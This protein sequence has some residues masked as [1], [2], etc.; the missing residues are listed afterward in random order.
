MNRLRRAAGA[1][2]LGIVLMSPAVRADPLSLLFVVEQQRA[3][4]VAKLARQW[5]DAF[6]GLPPERSLTHEQLSGRLW[7]LRADRLFAV[8]IAAD[9]ETVESVL[10][11]ARGPALRD[12]AGTKALGD[13]AADLTYT[14]VNPCRILDTRSTPAGPLAPGV[15]RTFDGYSAS[16]S[17]QGGTGSTC[18]IPN[19]V[20]ALAL[21]VYAVNPTNLGFIKVWPAN[22]V[23]P[24]V[25][26]VN[27][28]VG[29][30]AIA[31]G[32]LVPVEAANNNRFTAKSPATVDFIADVVGYFKPPGD[33]TGLDI[34]VAG[35]RVMRYE[36]NP[37]SPNLIGGS[38]ANY[39]TAGV[40]GATIGGGGV[41]TGD[42]DPDYV[43]EA[44]NS[45]T[46]VY[47]TVGGGY[48]N[49]A[50]DNLGTINDAGF[51]TVGGGY[52]N[53]AASVVATVGGGY[54]N[55][56]IGAQSTVAGGYQNKASGAGGTVGG[57][58]LNTAS[59]AFS[60]VV[61]GEQNLASGQNGSW[62][63]GASIRPRGTGRRW[64]AAGGTRPRRW[65][66]P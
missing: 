19:G 35:Q 1:L 32:A 38:P 43:N 46:D 44:P 59:G 21:N 12:R 42:T 14:P 28:Q 53:R 39:V 7:A 49:R 62:E 24:D 47:G 18:G 15:P 65:K 4:I 31:T 23:E 17:S 36:P 11:D 41:P 13:V 52:R 61:G 56:A 8:T 27:Y 26:T 66:A 58:D 29:I 2:V 57:G 40:R 55:A 10:T 6:A 25:S 16:F 63:A 54:E 45:V 37:I 33:A 20:S 22:A 50:G 51:A 60:T 3:A 9:A 64:A 48:A 34:K 5:T 30:T